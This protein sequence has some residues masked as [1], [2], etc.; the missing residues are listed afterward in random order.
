MSEWIA[1]KD[2]KPDKD[3]R[4]LVTNG[5]EVCEGDVNTSLRNGNKYT[6]PTHWMPLPS[7]PRKRHQCGEE[8][9]CFV[10]ED[11]DMY[12]QV[13]NIYGRMSILK[14]N[15]CPYCGVEN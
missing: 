1:Y 6:A 14:V 13:Y 5:I 10:D 15:Y 11:G 3:E 8:Y 4:C 2:R 9:E 12:L 7:P